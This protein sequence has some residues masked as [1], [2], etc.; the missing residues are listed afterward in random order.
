MPN[1]WAGDRT[2]IT[3]KTPDN[4]VVSVFNILNSDIQIIVD[5]TSSSELHDFDLS[6]TSSFRS[7]DDYFIA[8]QIR[9][10]TSVNI[11]PISEFALYIR[12][13]PSFYS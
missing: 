12:A 2:E 7:V 9:S 5:D 4:S 10:Y 11:K 8:L 3:E 6:I 13:P 1:D